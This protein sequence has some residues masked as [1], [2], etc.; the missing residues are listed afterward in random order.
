MGRG[1]QATH[2]GPHGA[3][4]H[5]TTPLLIV[6]SQAKHCTQPACSCTDQLHPHACCCHLVSY[7][8]YFHSVSLHREGNKAHTLK[9][10]ESKM[11]QETLMLHT[12][13]A[14]Q[15]QHCMVILEPVCTVL[16]DPSCCDICQRVKAVSEWLKCL[17]PFLE[18]FVIAMV[19]MTFVWFKVSHVKI[20]GLSSVKQ[21]HFFLRFCVD[22]EMC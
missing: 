11:S 12:V 2:Y 4:Q 21:Y 3:R 14:K 9:L 6:P 18:K 22:Y 7:C 17:L 15:I 19:L 20:N 1:C 16:T 5:G 8:L 10:G 13:A